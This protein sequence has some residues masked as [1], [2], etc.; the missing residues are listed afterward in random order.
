MRT[1]GDDAEENATPEGKSRI[2]KADE[3]CSP[4][5]NTFEFE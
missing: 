2:R 5:E 1:S 3:D 4:E